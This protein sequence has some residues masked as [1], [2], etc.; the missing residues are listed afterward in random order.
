MKIFVG[1]RLSA[2]DKDLL[3]NSKEAGDSWVFSQDLAESERQKAFEQSEVVFGNIPPQWLKKNNN[4]KWL[5]LTS[6]GF[7]AYLE[8]D[9]QALPQ[10]K[11]S[12]LRDFYGQ[13]VAE[14]AIAGIMA[15]FRRIDKLATLKD[16][17][18]WVGLDLRPE[19]ELLFG[20]NVLLLGAG[21]IGENIQ[22][23]LEAFSCEVTVVRKSSSP[24]LD[25]LDS[26]LPEADIII[27]TLPEN[28]ETNGIIDGKKIA[29]MKKDALFVNVGR[30][31]VVDE[32][33]LIA[34]IKQSKIKGAVLDVTQ[35]E[36]LSDD[37]PLWS[38][39]NVILT[40]HTGGGYR[41]EKSDIV[42]FFIQNLQRY[43]SGK[44][45]RHLVDFGKG[46]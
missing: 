22:K 29:L 9:W 35:V 5:Q 7:N 18:K 31:S 30:G 3:A 13:P 33:E 37:H 40:Q 26:L 45:P 24:N 1:Y 21:A 28:Q 32:E 11:V 34:A 14:T 17:R 10:V 4:L 2:S 39:P 25:D 20:K 43:R 42:R 27:A 6:T 46:Y 19:M 41:D 15:F 44:E 12:N 36:P 38:L 8:V 16:E 23:V